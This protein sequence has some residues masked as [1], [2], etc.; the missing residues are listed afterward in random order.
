MDTRP[1][2][3]YSSSSSTPENPWISK[4]LLKSALFGLILFSVIIG[5]LSYFLDISFLHSGA[6]PTIIT[7][8]L[9]WVLG[10]ASYEDKL[11]TVTTIT[12]GKHTRRALRPF[13][14]VL[15][16]PFVWPWL[17]TLLVIVGGGSYT[18]SWFSDFFQVL[19]R[20]HS[21]GLFGA[22]II[23]LLVALL[24]DFISA[25]RSRA[26]YKP[27]GPH[28]PLPIPSVSDFL[29]SILLLRV[30]IVIAF[31]SWTIALVDLS[32]A[33]GLTEIYAA[34]GFME[35]WPWNILHGIRNLTEYGVLPLVVIAGAI[36]YAV[37]VE[38]YYS[39]TFPS[40]Y[41]GLRSAM[42]FS[43]SL[44][45]RL[46][47]WFWALTAFF[48]ASSETSTDYF[49]GNFAVVTSIIAPLLRWQVQ[50]ALVL[51]I[52]AETL[53]YANE[54]CAKLSSYPKRFHALGILTLM[55]SIF[56]ACWGIIV[57]SYTYPDETSSWTQTFSLLKELGYGAWLGTNPWAAVID[58][59]G[60]ILAI[61]F[62][63]VAVIALLSSG[64][65][66]GSG[67]GGGGGGGGGYSSDSKEKQ[68]VVRTDFT[69]RKLATS[70]ISFNGEILDNEWGSPIGRIDRDPF[71]AIN[72]VEWEGKKAEVKHHWFDSGADLWVDGNMV[73]QIREE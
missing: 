10:W 6:I 23:T 3:D 31:A 61:I 44:P 21:N 64:G 8:T 26:L 34:S 55:A 2:S 51:L 29:L 28:E 30:G 46:L 9:F 20:F 59:V 66:S 56:F 40:D 24:G 13:L 14:V 32:Q 39:E 33:I 17:F 70:R 73:G 15:A 45:L 52:L 48:L 1:D 5:L 60:I 43:A 19:Y 42:I 72:E 62:A 12:Y 63:I 68:T 71:G 7:F 58:T 18:P 38:Q 41:S 37:S 35:P 4:Y 69:G 67:S 16:L 36:G 65:D 54:N 27:D 22:T 11:P 57:R 53:Y 47:V 49:P 50:V 25:R